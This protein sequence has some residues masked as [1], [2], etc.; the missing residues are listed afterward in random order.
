M[1]HPMAIVVRVEH[2]V[3]DYDTWKR[4]G[5]DRDPLGRGRSGVRRHRVLRRGT[6]PSVVAI[7]L[8]F[9]DRASAEAFAA[10]LRDMW[11]RVRERFAWRELPEAEIFEL[12]EARDY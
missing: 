12:T 3:P 10:G 2:P 11:G 9:E 8:E 6:S 7:E 4:E 1:A 5:F